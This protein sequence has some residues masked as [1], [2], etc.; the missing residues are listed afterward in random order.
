MALLGGE[1]LVLN[2][3]MKMVALIVLLSTVVAMFFLWRDVAERSL[4]ENAAYK[5]PMQ[6]YSKAEKQMVRGRFE[7]AL[8]GYA[9]AEKMLRAIPGIDLS[10]DFYF[11]IV[12]NALGTIHLRIGIYGD[13][14]KEIKSRADLAANKNEILA[15]LGYFEKSIAAYRKWLNENRPNPETLAKLARSREGLAADKIELEPFERY[16]RALSVSLT[17]FGMAHRYLAD[18]PLAEKAYLEALALWS[19]NDTAAANLES[20]RKTLSEN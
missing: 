8:K 3:K 7:Q 19:E 4:G 11:A 9:E 15:G 10:S 2:R 12:N 1:L 13:G 6:V 17:N 18:Y 14:G 16:E 5:A 20:M